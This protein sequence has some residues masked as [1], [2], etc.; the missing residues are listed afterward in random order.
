VSGAHVVGDAEQLT[1]AI[2]NILDNA[3]R[4]AKGRISLSLGE[5]DGMAVLTIADDGPG[6]PREQTDRVFERFG[7][8]DEA[9]GASTGGAGLGLAITRD[10]IERHRGSI[11]LITNASPGATFELRIPLAD[12]PGHTG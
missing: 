7:R 3:E 4:Y 8:L 6:I 2:R 11:G 10:I 9:R 12:Q 1:R 5:S